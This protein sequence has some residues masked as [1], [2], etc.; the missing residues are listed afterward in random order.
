M[1]H[2]LGGSVWQELRHCYHC[3]HKQY[4]YYEKTSTA[5]SIALYSARYFV[6]SGDVERD[7][8]KTERKISPPCLNHDRKTYK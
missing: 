2:Q 4:R 5:R 7:S 1:M 3:G 6:C 8:T